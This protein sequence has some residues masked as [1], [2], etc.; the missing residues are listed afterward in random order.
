MA[1]DAARSRIECSYGCFV[2]KRGRSLP[3]Y[4]SLYCCRKLDVCKRFAAL[5]RP[6]A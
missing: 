6:R 5:S 3:F 2:F 1:F 4:Y